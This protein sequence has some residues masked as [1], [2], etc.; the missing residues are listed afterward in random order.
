MFH[1]I[2]NL[3]YRQRSIGTSVSVGSSIG[4]HSHSPQTLNVHRQRNQ[5]HLQN[6]AYE[7]FPVAARER[8]ASSTETDSVLGSTI[9]AAPSS[10]SY[11]FPVQ[12]MI[13]L[14]DPFVGPQRNPKNLIDLQLR[15]NSHGSATSNCES[16]LTHQITDAAIK[17]LNY[18]RRYSL[19]HIDQASIDDLVEALSPIKYKDVNSP[20]SASTEP[21]LP[22]QPHRYCLGNRTFT[23]IQADSALNR[24]INKKSL[25]V[26][27]DHTDEYSEVVR[28]LHGQTVLD[29]APGEDE[30]DMGVTYDKAQ[31]DSKYNFLS[32]RHHRSMIDSSTQ[33]QVANG[34]GSAWESTVRALPLS[35]RNRS[36]SNTSKRKRS[37]SPHSYKKIGELMNDSSEECL[38]PQKENQRHHVAKSTS[39]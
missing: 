1:N 25:C 27:E 2:R 36:D 7:G 31:S 37:S 38:S 21:S 32:P 12:N 28:S 33:S 3:V 6:S 30:N 9:A 18:S 22:P 19:Q 26:N 24:H 16:G 39:C 35:S 34:L 10:T 23:K 8:L 29:L 14:E 4:L 11:V 17:E 15:N 13:H 20:V 5:L